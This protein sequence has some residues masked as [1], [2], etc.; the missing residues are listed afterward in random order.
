MLSLC[1]EYYQIFFAQGV[2]FGIAASGL[3]SCATTS[4]GQWFHKRKALALGVVLAGSS[5]GIFFSSNP[6]TKIKLTYLTRW[7]H[8][9]PVS[10]HPH[11]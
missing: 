11:Q 7:C 1:T 2:G 4:T 3:F 8:S 9:F 6:I 10:T 5:T